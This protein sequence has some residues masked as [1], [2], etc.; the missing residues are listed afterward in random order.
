[1]SSS[2]QVRARS[3]GTAPGQN[4]GLC[5]PLAPLPWPPVLTRKVEKEASTSTLISQMGRSQG[6]GLGETCLEMD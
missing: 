3:P 6:S 5:G 4:R 2:G 1:M